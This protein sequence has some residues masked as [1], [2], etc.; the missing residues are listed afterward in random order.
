MGR[1]YFLKKE[2]G[3]KKNSV[4]DQQ[5]HTK[6]FC[7]TEVAKMIGAMVRGSNLKEERTKKIL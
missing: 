7:E 1:N 3:R 5:F 2:K 4:K 6:K